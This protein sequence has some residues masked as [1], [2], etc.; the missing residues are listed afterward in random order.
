MKPLTRFVW[1]VCCCCLV[2]SYFILR[3][4]AVTP[5][6][7]AASEQVEEDFMM[8]PAMLDSMADITRVPTLQSGVIQQI[9]VTVGQRVHQ[10][11]VLFVLDDTLANQELQIRKI[12]VAQAKN[13]VVIQEKAF[14]HAQEQLS[15]LKTI[16][17]RAISQADLR[18]KM[19][20]VIMGRARL[21][22]ALQ[23][24]ALA[25]AN[26]QQAV[27]TKNQY[28]VRAPKA[29]V[30]LQVSAHENEFVGA[31]QPMI[32][33]ADAER[34]VVRV[35]L[36]ERDA[37]R[38]DPHAI[39]YLTSNDDSQLKVPLHYLSSDQYIITQERLNSRVRELTYYFKRDE[40]PN[41]IAGQQL[42]ATIY[43]RKTA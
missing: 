10:G 20:E 36:D 25:E 33:L 24:L 35:S 27:M 5:V 6:H 42:N 2:V 43:L 32:W 4:R 41:L 34:V 29:G 13:Q 14:A 40:Y 15:R 16:D 21:K 11:Q 23:S 37:Q 26:Y 1:L 9:A 17:T 30:V 3:P 12:T 31:A 19:H 8:A 39:V 28:T 22:Q 38:F 7:V 18:E